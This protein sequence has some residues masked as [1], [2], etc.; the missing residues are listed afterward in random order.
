LARHGGS[1]GGT[2]PAKTRRRPSTRPARIVVFLD[3]EDDLVE[4][5]AGRDGVGGLVDDL[6][7][8]VEPSGKMKWQVAP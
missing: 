6:I 4:I 1:G 5:Q 7:A 3:E 2:S 8:G